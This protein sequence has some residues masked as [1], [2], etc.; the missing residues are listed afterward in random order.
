MLKV[1]DLLAVLQQIVRRAMAMHSR[2]PRGSLLLR[3][4]DRLVARALLG[5]D[6]PPGHGAHAP[7]AAELDGE[8]AA[9]A[10]A[11]PEDTRASHVV[12]ARAWYRAYL[13]FALGIG[14]AIPE[15]AGVLVA[16]IQLH[17]EVVG[18]LAIEQ[19]TREPPDEAR[20]ATIE[21]L[22][23]AAGDAL[24]RHR[25]YDDKASAAQEIRLFE[26]LLGAV[27]TTVELHDLVETVAHGIKS[28]QLDADWNAVELWLL[29]E[30][31]LADGPAPAR[32][33]LRAR[34]Y[35]APTSEPTTYWQ[36]IRA[37]ADSAARPLGVA[38][39]FRTGDGG[40]G[41]GSQRALLDEAIR[42]RVSGII[43]APGNPESAEE[44]FRQAADAAIPVVVIDAP[45]IPGSRAP[46]Y[47]GTDNVASGRLAAEMMRRLLP[48]GGVVAALGAVDLAPNVR[49]RVEGFCAAARGSSLT[50][51][52]TIACDWDLA[53]GTRLAT[54][55]LTA[56]PDVAGAFGAAADNGP[57]WGLSARA[58]GRAGELKVV[59]FDLIASTVALLRQGAIHATIVQREY[60]MGFRAV[61]VIH[62]MIAQGVGPTL[63]AL[64]PS[65]VLH[66]GVDCVTLERTPWS[67]SLSDYL[68]LDAARRVAVGQG[69]RGASVAPAIEV[70]L[71]G[72]PPPSRSVIEGQVTISAASLVGRA[73]AAGSPLAIDPEGD[74]APRDAAL[75]A[76]HAGARTAVALPLQARGAVLGA[77]VLS[78]R[79]GGACARRQSDLSFLVRV[80]G[81]VAVGVE[82]ARL[83]RRISE[84]KT[85][86][87]RANE[88]QAAMLQTIRELS[89]PVVPIADGILVMPVIGVMDVERSGRFIES[90]IRAIDAQRARVVLIDVTGM[91]VVDAS[92]ASQL[93][94]A[95]RAA[96]LLGAEAVLVGVRPEAAQLMVAQGLDVGAMATQANLASGFRYAL[97]RTRRRAARRG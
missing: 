48:G 35:R 45:P 50:V 63:A 62:R 66:T 43:V 30:D 46:L 67:T 20:R 38:V 96:A 16:P 79:R 6:A 18:Y 81:T 29:E 4:G 52:P 41:E 47:I 40:E 25:L 72:F 59:G 37:G 51:L 53:A 71:I 14:G 76:A 7:A 54:A 69:G 58:L 83:F 36:N 42:R 91:A 56:R 27:G 34:V 94:Q 92:A 60:D 64:P 70:M 12:D 3:E 82:N 80:A 11:A 10:G 55:A 85:A 28:V 87:E 57:S 22:A 2:A 32:G 65:R 39:D 84:R 88:Q 26:R 89:S 31:G 78:S 15:G 49:E 95:A 61:E 73:I 1:P 21:V 44:A 9:L 8:G 19:E 97:E 86:L 90:M 23:G 77:L 5:F 75:P 68:T 13:P 74:A 93:V 33:E 17:G 24:E